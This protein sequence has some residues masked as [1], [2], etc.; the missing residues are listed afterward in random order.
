MFQI[1]PSLGEILQT[2]KPDPVACTMAVGATFLRTSGLNSAS[3]SGWLHI[4]LITLDMVVMIAVDVAK[5]INSQ[6]SSWPKHDS[7]DAGRCVLLMSRGVGVSQLD[8]DLHMLLL[9]LACVQCSRI[10]SRVGTH[11]AELPLTAQY[12]PIFDGPAPFSQLIFQVMRECQQRCKD[13]RKSSSTSSHSLREN[14]AHSRTVISSPLAVQ[15]SRNCGITDESPV[16]CF[17]T[18]LYDSS[19]CIV[20]RSSVLRAPS[21]PGTTTTD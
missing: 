1:E 11:H 8:G 3:A 12:R 15:S 5:P 17:Y 9:L 10:A 21:S 7:Q 4:H 2:A 6:G 16:H 20:R 19:G 18:K 13:Y 14:R